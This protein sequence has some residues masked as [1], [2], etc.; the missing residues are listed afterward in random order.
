[1]KIKNTIEIS[2]LLMYNNKMKLKNIIHKSI[3]FI[4]KNNLN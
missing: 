4:M 1:M 3:K 2:N